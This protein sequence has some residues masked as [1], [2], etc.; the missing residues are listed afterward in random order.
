VSDTAPGARV[1]IRPSD[2]DMFRL[3]TKE[4]YDE[5]F[6]AGQSA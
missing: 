2:T 5:G 6:E 4:A 3:G 1:L